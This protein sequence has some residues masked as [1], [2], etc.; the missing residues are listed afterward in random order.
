MTWPPP[1]KAVVKVHPQMGPGDP[2]SIVPVQ[3][4][5]QSEKISA[6]VHAGVG[7][8]AGAGVVPGTAAPPPDGQRPLAGP[9]KG[10][11]GDLG[12]HGPLGLWR[13]NGGGHLGDCGRCGVTIWL[14][15][16]AGHLEIQ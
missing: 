13:T 10:V 7:V 6:V 14:I 15:I 11:T 5:K 2:T 4:R 1:P 3:N 12:T 8:G 9:P 16:E